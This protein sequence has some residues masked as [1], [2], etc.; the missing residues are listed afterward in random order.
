MDED[1]DDPMSFC[2]DLLTL[3]KTEAFP[4][5]LLK[6]R[7]PGEWVPVKTVCQSAGIASQELR[8]ELVSTWLPDPFG[9]QDFV[10]II[11]FDDET[12]RSMA[13][14]YNKRLLLETHSAASMG[15]EPDHHAV[16]GSGT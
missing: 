6:D 4:L 16:L 9:D 14:N 1:G 3:R 8:P 2:A 10:I 11:F 15:G 13:A 7:E 5:G 12:K